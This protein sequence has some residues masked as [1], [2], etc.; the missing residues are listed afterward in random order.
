MSQNTSCIAI[1]W[2]TSSFRAVELDTDGRVLR[3]REG[4]WGILSV[5]NN[6]FA[7]TLTQHLGE[8]LED[9]TAPI[10]M[11]GMIGSRQGWAEAPYVEAPADLETLASQLMMIEDADRGIH[12][13]PGVQIRQGDFYDVMRGEE[14]QI[15][16]ALTGLA[17]DQ[18]CFVLPGTHSKWVHVQNGR[19]VG[20][21]TYMTGEVFDVAHRHTILGRLMTEAEEHETAYTSGVEDGAR[22]GDPGALLSRLFQVRTAGL[23]GRFPSSALRDYL[24]GL[25]IGAEVKSAA[26]KRDGSLYVIGQSALAVRYERALAHLG[27]SAIKIEPECGFDGLFSIG[28]RAGIL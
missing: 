14:T 3:R 22:E 16:G 1:D 11:C 24:S 8:W 13:V 26:F 4:P 25:L 10:L 20:F 9:S 17:I 28:R 21:D 19:I 7:E 6:A 18:G 5:T 23:F 15:F 2:G 27:Q 12:I